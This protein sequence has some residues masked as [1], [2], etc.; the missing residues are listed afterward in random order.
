MRPS[1]RLHTRLQLHRRA[2]QLLLP[3]RRRIRLLLH[4]LQLHLLLRVL[5]LRL[6]VMLLRL[7][8]QHFLL[9][10]L[11]LLLPLLLLLLL[12]L[13][14]LRLLL[15][16]LL[17]MVLRMVLRLVL[18]YYPRQAVASYLLPGKRCLSGAYLL[19]QL[20]PLALVGGERSDRLA[21]LGHRL[22]GGGLAVGVGAQ[23]ASV[24]RQRVRR[25]HAPVVLVSV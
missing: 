8:Q 10:R 12:H 25:R 4:L 13:S 21:R 15:R 1:P 9:Q 5:Q 18:H 14:L 20:R 11:V 3:A 17:R 24:A 23:P 6:R 22:G 19:R 7:L 16:L 2:R